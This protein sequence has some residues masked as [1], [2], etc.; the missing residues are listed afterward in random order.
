LKN[1]VTDFFAILYYIFYDMDNIAVL[2]SQTFRYPYCIMPNL[3]YH[4]LSEPILRLAD[5][6]TSSTWI[7]VKAVAD[8]AGPG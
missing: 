5:K 8:L 3:R 2:I 7:N 1:V 6:P 4:E